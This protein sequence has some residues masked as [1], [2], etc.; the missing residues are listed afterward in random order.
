MSESPPQKRLPR[1]AAPIPF[2][3]SSHGTHYLSTSPRSFLSDQ[4]QLS[5]GQVS[6]HA[7]DLPTRSP[8]TYSEIEVVLDD[9]TLQKRTVS[10][11]TLPEVE[12]HDTA[13]ESTEEDH[14]DE[15]ETSCNR[16]A[17]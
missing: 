9:G 8:S 1:N 7:L 13:E 4:P 3:A 16:H 14:P 12:Q 11:S 15:E 5:F 17:R 6:D 10:L 2:P